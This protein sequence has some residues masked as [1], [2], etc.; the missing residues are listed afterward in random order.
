MF[1]LFLFVFVAENVSIAMARTARRSVASDHQSSP[2]TGHHTRE[3][4]PHRSAGHLSAN[5]FAQEAT[6][7]THHTSRRSKWAQIPRPIYN[8]NSRTS[9]AFSNV[10]CRFQFSA[11]PKMSVILHSAKIEHE[12]R[13]QRRTHC[14][15]TTTLSMQRQRRR[16]NTS[17][18]NVN[19]L[20]WSFMPRTMSWQVY[21]LQL[22]SAGFSV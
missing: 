16:S 3:H 4:R 10:Y 11:I 2:K 8:T 1:V 17:P 12:H 5:G 22:R 18:P 9:Y 6:N 20:E 14:P 21:E 13:R 7:T 15:S 19:E